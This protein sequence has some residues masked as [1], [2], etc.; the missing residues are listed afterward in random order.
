M[1]NPFH[2]MRLLLIVFLINLLPLLS[3]DFPGGSDSKESACNAG[4]QGLIPSWGTKTLQAMW[5]GQ[6]KKKRGK[7]GIETEHPREGNGNPLQYSCLGNPRTEEPGRLQSIVP[8]SV[9]HN[10]ATKQQP[11]STTHTHTHKY[12]YK[13]TCCH[14]RQR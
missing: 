6:K 10:L 13:I 8:Q 3:K 9:R 7:G 1:I 11:H 2:L 12:I 14:L 5:C 4:N